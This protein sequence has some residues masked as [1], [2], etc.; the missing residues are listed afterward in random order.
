MKKEAWIVTL[1]EVFYYKGF[2]HDGPDRGWEFTPYID[3]AC[4]FSTKAE[5]EATLAGVTSVGDFKDTRGLVTPT[6][7]FGMRKMTRKEYNEIKKR[8]IT[9]ITF[10]A[11]EQGAA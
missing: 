7:A 3:Q 10:R 6:T 9:K 8:Q 2:L 11:S 5:A 1:D 4:Y